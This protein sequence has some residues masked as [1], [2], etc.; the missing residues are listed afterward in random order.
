MRSM[1]GYT[2]IEHHNTEQD[3]TVEIRSVNNRYLEIAVN[4]PAFLTALEPEVKKRIAAAAHR[5][6]IEVNVR[7]RDQSATT[8]IKIDPQAVRAAKAIL[9]EIRLIA[10]VQTEP[11]YADILGFE[12][13]V[14]TGAHT[15]S[16]HTRATILDV[17]AEAVVQW[18]RS[19]ATEGEAT[20]RDIRFH[21]QRVEAAASV[22]REHRKEAERVIHETVVQKFHEILGDAADEQRVYAEVASL[23]LRHSVSEE[24]AR[25]E[26][27]ILAFRELFKMEGPVGKRMDFI[28]QEMNREINTTGSK[29]NLAVVQDAVV[30]AKDAVEAIREQLRNIE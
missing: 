28:C 26:S 16:S 29:T 5:G 10:G 9:D 20:D 7:L 6:K 17:V 4:L 22:F 11:T 14:Y 21:L 1:T 19:R 8:D 24:V 23:I 13:V 18:N 2:V 12:G 15:E 27:H 3:L 25:L 30:D